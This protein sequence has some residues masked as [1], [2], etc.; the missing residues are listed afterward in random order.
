MWLLFQLIDDSL[1]L[2]R[3]G[4]I[5]YETPFEVVLAMEH[6]TEYA[7]WKAFIRNMDFL[8][9]RLVALVEEDEDLDP[10]IYLVSAMLFEGLFVIKWRV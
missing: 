4:L 3:A 5:D 9:R 7:P 2:A 10:D 6:E 8:R 1:N